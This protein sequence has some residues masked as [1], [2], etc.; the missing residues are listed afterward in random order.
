MIVLVS[1]IGL[2]VYPDRLMVGTLKKNLNGR[3]PKKLMLFVGMIK[4]A[5]L[6]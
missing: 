3:G 2:G 4:E 6:C 5:Y 1:L